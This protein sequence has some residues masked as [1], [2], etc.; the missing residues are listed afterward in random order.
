MKIVKLL[1]LIILVVCIGLG[2]KLRLEAGNRFITS[3]E[4]TLN[5]CSQALTFLAVGVI[6]GI[7][8][9]AFPDSIVNWH[10]KNISTGVRN[11]FSK[12]NPPHP[13]LLRIFG[14]VLLWMA[15][16]NPTLWTECRSAY[17]IS[18]GILLT[19][20]NGARYIPKAP[21]T[22]IPTS[23]SL[24]TSENIDKLTE[25]ASWPIDGW[26]KLCILFSPDNRSLAFAYDEADT[27]PPIQVRE[28]ATGYT[29]R[30]LTGVTSRM[31]RY[32]S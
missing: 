14:F 11:P 6:I 12:L 16:W 19:A 29:A 27:P 5:R 15:F 18:G 10:K 30:M 8:M 26:V 7:Y 22:P 4:L 20:C 23:L 1:V 21:G 13:L 2:L 31:E 24:I 17:Y 9:V 28:V 3:E 32:R 25:L